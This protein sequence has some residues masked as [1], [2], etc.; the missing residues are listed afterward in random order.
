MSPNAQ[1]VKTFTVT[2]L[3]LREV[4]GLTGATGTYDRI[5]HRA[6]MITHDSARRGICRHIAGKKS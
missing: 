6:H 2:T 1:T 4:S 3:E 5:D